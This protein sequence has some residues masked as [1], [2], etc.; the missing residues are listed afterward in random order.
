[1]VDEFSLEAA[2][3][4]LEEAFAEGFG[5][6][7]E[8]AAAVFDGFCQGFGSGGIE[9][10]GGHFFVEDPEVVFGAEGVFKVIEEGDGGGEFF[11]PEWGE[12][13]EL[14]VD[15][16]YGDAPRVE[17]F[18]AGGFDGLFHALAGA[19]EFASEG[20][21]GPGGAGEIDAEEGALESG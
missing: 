21:G 20:E 15:A 3:V 7:A 9:G 13:L 17:G 8:V 5:P 10:E 16:L 11:G 2:G 4:V 14:I 19:V 6:A 18:G 1:M 12:P